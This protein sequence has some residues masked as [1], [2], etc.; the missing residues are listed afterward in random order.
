MD[1]CSSR[2]LSEGD[3]GT[4][5]IYGHVFRRLAERRGYR[6]GSAV[7]AL[8]EIARRHLFELAECAGEK[9]LVAETDFPGDFFDRESRANHQQLGLLD[10]VLGQVFQRGTAERFPHAPSY[11]DRV[12]IEVALQ[13]LVRYA[14]A[15]MRAEIDGD[16]LGELNGARLSERVLFFGQYFKQVLQVDLMLPPSPREGLT[17]QLDQF[18]K[19]IVDGPG[20][21][22][23]EIL[24]NAKAERARNE[25]LFDSIF[26]FT[27]QV[28]YRGRIVRRTIAPRRGRMKMK[29]KKSRLGF[30]G[31]R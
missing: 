18:A 30:D 3:F 19:A 10:P 11:I 8:A 4:K 15:V 5:G 27:V 26:I 23:R 7:E 31:A 16:P 14:R 13:K 29:P 24:R 21:A 25:P 22:K 1:M 2:S 12:K 9:R 28:L 20:I 6:Y 17:L